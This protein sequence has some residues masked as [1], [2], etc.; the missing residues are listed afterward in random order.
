MQGL[1]PLMPGFLLAGLVM[2]RCAELFFLYILEAGQGYVPP[3]AGSAS[4]A[5]PAI[6]A[7]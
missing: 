6:L 3:S 1:W 7:Q 4:A 5:D 2:V